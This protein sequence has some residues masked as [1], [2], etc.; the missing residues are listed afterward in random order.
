MSPSLWQK[1]LAAIR[2][3]VGA[4]P[5]VS[6]SASCMKQ[7]VFAKNLENLCKKSSGT[8]NRPGGTRKLKEN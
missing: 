1:I 2:R 3:S 5:A 4:S 8:I 7:K 6:K